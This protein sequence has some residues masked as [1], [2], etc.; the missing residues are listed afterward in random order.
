MPTLLGVWLTRLLPSAPR[1]LALVLPGRSGRSG[2]ATGAAA[3]GSAAWALGLG[4]RNVPLKRLSLKQSPKYLKG[5]HFGPNMLQV[6]QGRLGLR[7]KQAGVGVAKWVYSKI[8]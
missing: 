4:L 1:G 6:A 3:G 2:A 5:A 8:G 7:S